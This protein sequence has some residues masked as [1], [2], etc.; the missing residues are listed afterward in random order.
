M[1]RMIANNTSDYV[2]TDL[3]HQLWCQ[4][5]EKYGFLF[6]DEPHQSK[7]ACSF[8]HFEKNY[9][10]SNDKETT[11]QIRN[12]NSN[13]LTGGDYA[14][15]GQVYDRNQRKI[16]NRQNLNIDNEYFGTDRIGNNSFETVSNKVYPPEYFVE[17]E[18]ISL[19]RKRDVEDSSTKV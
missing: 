7:T 4:H 18:D 12:Q 17:N 5:H 11:N 19:I 9:S 13:E 15:F 2:A 14:S 3:V 8:K 1:L 6:L 16:T 10:G